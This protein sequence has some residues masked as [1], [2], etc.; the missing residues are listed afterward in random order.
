[1]GVM[2]Q[3]WESLGEVEDPGLGGCIA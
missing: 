3:A 2:A 1:M